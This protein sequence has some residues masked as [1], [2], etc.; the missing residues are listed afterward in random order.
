MYRIRQKV[1][2]WYGTSEKLCVVAS[3][4][5]T[6]SM[7]I[8]DL[9]SGIGGFHLAA[10]TADSRTECVLACDICPRAR[11]I[12][13]RNFGIEPARD[14]KEL[15]SLPRHDI[16]CAGFPCQSFS[17]IGHEKGLQ[18]DQ[19]GALIWETIRLAE[20]SKPPCILLENVRRL[21]TLNGGSVLHAILARLQ[22]IGY[23]TVVR[24]LNAMQYGLPQ[25]RERLFIVAFLSKDAAARFQWPEPKTVVPLNTLLE[26]HVDQ[27][28]YASQYIRD[29]TFARRGPKA[30]DPQNRVWIT[31]KG[32][33]VSHRP[34]ALTLRADPSYNSL[35]ID[36][37]RRLTEREMLR[38]QGFPEDY[39]MEGLSYTAA[40]ALIGNSVPVAVVAAIMESIIVAFSRV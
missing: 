30:A 32:N 4:A 12:Y 29:L 27:R 40:R 22:K 8:V 33:R 18:D 7:R 14:V 20:A 6:K 16:L 39:N 34:Y 28:Y 35:L 9:F 3:S 5:A 36:G 15:T 25:R 21:A 24:I 1:I 17:M 23:S 38:L 37:K 2:R 31:D 11:D 10:R 26:L 19:R 13:A